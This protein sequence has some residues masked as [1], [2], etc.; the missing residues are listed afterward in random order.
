MDLKN[1]LKN[2]P[3]IYYINLDE[4][5][6][7]KNYIESQF[8]ELK[9]NHW[10]RYSASKY[11]AKNFE[12]WKSLLS[13]NPSTN[14]TV[15]DITWTSQTITYLNLIEDWLTKTT[16][17]YIIIIEDDYDLLMSK[18][19]HFDWDFF[20]NNIPYDWDI[21]QLS[22]ENVHLYPC[23][24][25]PTM[26]SSGIGALLINRHFAEKLIR[27]HKIDGKYSIH[28][29]KN[30]MSS[31]YWNNQG[32]PTNIQEFLVM[33]YLVKMGRSYSIPLMYSSVNWG[34]QDELDNMDPVQYK[35][36]KRCE[37]ACKYW[38]I[39]LR[40]KFTLEEFFTYGKPNDKYIIFDKF[41]GQYQ[42]L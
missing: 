24:L 1:K 3:K 9:I 7:R 22:Y 16:D 28:K 19:W 39:K 14:S 29:S 18:Y 41:L 36:F 38:W 2:L 4:R 6:D 35:I 30:K 31:Y 37:Y 34:R 11:K 15:E 25:H 20:M 21:I 5:T 8:D 17:E 42:I 12:D 10:E 32:E 40:D 23:F 13:Y 27:L 33:D 26:D